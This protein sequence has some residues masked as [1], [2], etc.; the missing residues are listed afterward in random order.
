MRVFGLDAGIQ[1]LAS[2]YTRRAYFSGG[3]VWPQQELYYE[4]WGEVDMF[5]GLPGTGEDY[6]ISK[7]CKDMPVISLDEIR[8][9]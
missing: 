2:D 3:D 8:N 1:A 4:T 9:R 7:H 6:W 5:C